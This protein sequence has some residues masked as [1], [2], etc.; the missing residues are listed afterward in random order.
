VD[1]RIADDVIELPRPAAT[2]KSPEERFRYGSLRKRQAPL[3]ERI[4]LLAQDE[5]TPGT[6]HPIHRAQDAR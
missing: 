4:G 2:Y 5:G 3:N 1:A 6:L